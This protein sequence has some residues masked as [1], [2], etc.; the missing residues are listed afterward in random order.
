MF[1]EL[2]GLPEMGLTGTEK[3]MIQFKP[4]RAIFH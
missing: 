1:D 4:G 2:A 3:A